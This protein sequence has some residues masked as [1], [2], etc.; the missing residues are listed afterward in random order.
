MGD[1]AKAMTKA[2]RDELINFER[3]SR[4][5]CWSHVHRNITPQ[6][7]S[8]ATFSAELSENILNDIQD[9]FTMVSS[10]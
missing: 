4:L 8:I 3:S 7:G 5:M 2:G 1:G 10:E 9:R 6:L